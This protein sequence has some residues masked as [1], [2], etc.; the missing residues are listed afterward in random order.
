[1]VLAGG[2][3]FLGG[4]LAADFAERGWRVVI[5]SRT[6]SNGGAG[7]IHFEGWD[8]STQGAWTKQLEAADVVVNLTGRSVNCRYDEANRAEI[9][10]SR[11]R[12]V[13][14]LAAGIATCR[15]PPRLWIQAGSLAI[16]G[17]AGDRLCDESTPAGEGFSVDVCEQWETAFRAAQVAPRKVLLRIGLV[18]GPDGGVLRPLVTLT[19]CFLGG[20]VAGGRQ[21]LSWIHADDFTRIVHWCIDHESARGVYNATGLASSTNSEF[22]WSLRRALGRPWAPPTPAWLVRIGA[23]LIMNTEPDLALT[24]RRGFPLRLVR[25]GF[26]FEHNDLTAALRSVL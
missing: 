15:T 21:H 2:S 23:R 6:P 7:N 9:V 1:M 25:E 10:E 4:V 24:G 13:Q 18:L 16:Y 3:G 11:V 22:M 5:L 8:G 14:A 17:D 26:E 20:T 12:S 19:R